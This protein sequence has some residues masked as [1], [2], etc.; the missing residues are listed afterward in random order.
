MIKTSAEVYFTG[1]YKADNWCTFPAYFNFMSLL[2]MGLYFTIISLV[3]F[4]CYISIFC[5]VRNG[6]KKR[7]QLGMYF[8]ISV[9]QDDPFSR[10]CTFNQ[11]R[12]A[13]SSIYL[14]ISPFKVKRQ[15]LASSL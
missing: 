7:K 1:S 6:Q 3:T 2:I 5:K 9:T 13:I 11:R 15:S 14:S 10:P 8:N 4:G 12:N